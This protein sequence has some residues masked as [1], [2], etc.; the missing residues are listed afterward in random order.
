MNFSKEQEEI[1]IYNK[2]LVVLAN[3]GSGKTFTLSH[4]IKSIL[5]SLY[6][7]QG[8]IAISYT[9]KASDELKYRSL[10]GY[11]DKKASFFG[12]IDKFYLTE[13]IYPFGNHIFNQHIETAD[14]EIIDK[15]NDNKKVKKF[16]KLISQENFNPFDKEIINYLKYFF[17]NGQIL[18]ETIGVLAIYIFD[19]CM[20]CQKYLKSRYTHLVIDEYQDCGWEQH[21]IFLRL[22]KLGLTCIAV[23]DENQ[24]IY[25][26]SNKSSKYLLTLIEHQEFKS[27]Y[28]NKNYRCH[29]SIVNYSL[30]MLDANFAVSET[31]EK[32][33]QAFKIPGTQKDIVKFIEKNVTKIMQRFKVK[34]YNKVGILV[35]GENTGN[36]VEGNLNLPFKYFKN[37]PLDSDSSLWG[38][39]FKKLLLWS[40]DENTTSYEFVEEYFDVTTISKDAKGIIKLLNNIKQE[41]NL[42]EMKATLIKTAQKIYPNAYNDKA[43]LKLEEVL[44][45]KEYMDSY[46]PALENEIQVMT[47]HK[48]KGLE[49]DIVFHLDLYEYVIPQQRKVDGIWEF[50]DYRQCLNLHYVGVTRAKEFCCLLTSTQRINNKG[51]IKIGQP[52]KFLS[53]PGLKEIRSLNKSK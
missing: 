29:S 20:T 18:I 52:S 27:F 26:F 36:I 9:N 50:L 41:N 34:S 2:S 12:T 24:S 11:I 48:S 35:R 13:I 1:I 16:R 53:F 8:V 43:I 39:V 38:G 33:V 30:K 15:E 47:L 42:S 19:N 10:K 6:D 25:G 44:M 37:T 46:R 5:P 51:E 45:S 17:E 14:F 7:H 23:G 31:K 21:N 4:K 32:R 22:H 28:L 40:L 3:P 49:F